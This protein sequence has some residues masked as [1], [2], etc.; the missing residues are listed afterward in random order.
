MKNFISRMLFAIVGLPILDCITTLCTNF[1]NHSSYKTALKV[2]K[3]KNQIAELAISEEEQ[4]SQIG[5]VG[6]AIEIEDP[7]ITLNQEEQER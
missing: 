1:T 4:P 2:Q 7:E 6:P 5:F 3:I